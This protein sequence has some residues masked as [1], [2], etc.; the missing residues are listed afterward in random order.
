VSF[1]EHWPRRRWWFVARLPLAQLA[2]HEI[3][4]EREPPHD[5]VS[6]RREATS[7]R[8]AILPRAVYVAVVRLHCAIL[9][10]RIE[11]DR[12]A[13]ASSSLISGW[14]ITLRSP[15]PRRINQAEMI[16]PR[17]WATSMTRCPPLILAERGAVAELMQRKQEPVRRDDV[18]LSSPVLT[19]RADRFDACGERRDR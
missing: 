7:R 9:V 11:A 5:P 3:E 12:G 2:T 19:E 18:Q 14:A 6:D 13:P 1:F 16:L 8:Q 15:E 4:R 10:R 17:R